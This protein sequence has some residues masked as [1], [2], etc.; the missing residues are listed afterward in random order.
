M[1]VTIHRTGARFERVVREESEKLSA[2]PVASRGC[3]HV[4]NSTECLCI[5]RKRTDDGAF[6]EHGG[7]YGREHAG[8]NALSV[9]RSLLGGT[10]REGSDRSRGR[11]GKSHDD[12]ARDDTN[13]KR[14]DDNIDF[15][16]RRRQKSIARGAGVQPVLH[17]VDRGGAGSG[18]GGISSA[19]CLLQWFKRGCRNSDTGE[20]LPALVHSSA[21]AAISPNDFGRD[22]ARNRNHQT[23][24]RFSGAQRGAQ[25]RARTT[26]DFRDRAVAAHGRARR[27]ARDL[28]FNPDRGCADADLFREEFSLCAV[29]RVAAASANQDLGENVERRPAAR[30]RSSRSRS[31]I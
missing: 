7:V 24:G 30:E 9:G 10:S 27:R 12:R 11:G 20:T 25:H 14:G 5:F 17:H 18:R 21:V 15:A 8:A 3:D 6:A 23:R 29:P 1:V 13:A 2:H 26:V 28:H 31:S 4:N 19:R 16:R 22:L